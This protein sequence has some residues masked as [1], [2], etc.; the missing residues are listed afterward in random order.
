M[1]R[2]A[3]RAVRLV[4]LPAILSLILVA[5]G[6][7][8]GGG[9]GGSQTQGVTSNE[10]D[11]GAI[12]A[13]TGP[14]ANQYGPITQGAQA[15][16]DQV[17]A[18][19][20][21][22][23]RKIKYV[24]QLDDQTLPSLD[25]SQARALVTQDNVFAVVGVAT[26]IFAAGKYLAQ[27]NIPTFGWNV[28][29]EWSDGPSLFGEKGSFI[30]FTHQG[31]LIAYLANKVGA[32]KVGV[33]AYTVSQSADCAT[34]SINTFQK[35]APQTGQQVVL[36][37]T[38]LPF[39][40]TDISGDITQLK[41]SGAQFVGTCMD[42]TG[43]TVLSKGLQEAGLNNQVKQYWPNGYDQSTL[44]QFAPLMEGVYFETGFVPY[45]YGFTQGMDNYLN[46]M[47]A[48]GAP[49]SDVTLA[50]WINADLFTTALRQVGPNVTRQ[51]VINTI[52]KMTHYTANGISPGIDWTQQHTNSGPNDCDAFL[53]VQQGKFTSVF[54]NGKNPFVCFQAPNAT[55]MNPV[56]F[57]NDP[58]TFFNST[59]PTPKTS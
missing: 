41:N 31:P 20:G 46:A 10:I 44:S 43:N 55:T 32:Q 49:V 57:P 27:N 35:F 6:N 53:Q 26:P 3:T 16:F 39:G 2:L 30:N 8:S 33:V 28:N 54:G 48:V 56:P 59:M 7:A 50:G 5:C 17:N 22:N 47:K 4:A 15:Y 42:P 38:S 36:K 37:D 12:A 51:N 25:V 13:K 18:A 34:G 24:A 14:L 19:G 29:P 1:P 23:G 11:I 52:N 58:T 45:Q 21:V 9:G 40:F